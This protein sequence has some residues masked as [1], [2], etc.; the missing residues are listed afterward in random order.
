MQAG[1]Y[2]LFWLAEGVVENHHAGM[3]CRLYDADEFAG[4]VIQL[5]EDVQLR[6]EMSHNARRLT[7][8]EFSRDRLD[9]KNLVTLESVL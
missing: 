5:Y 8:N 6:E 1:T 7:K 3:G 4:H 9:K 2:E